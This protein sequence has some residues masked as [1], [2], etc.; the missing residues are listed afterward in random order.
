MSITTPAAE[1]QRNLLNIEMVR[2]RLREDAAIPLAL[3]S[4]SRQRWNQAGLPSA[5]RLPVRTH[6]R[7]QPRRVR[8][9]RPEFERA[10]IRNG[11][12]ERSAWWGSRPAA[13]PRRM[14]SVGDPGEPVMSAS[15]L[16]AKLRQAREN[17][18]AA[19]PIEGARR[20]AD[21]AQD[22]ASD[23]LDPEDL[24]P[25]VDALAGALLDLCDAIEHALAAASAR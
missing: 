14:A 2:K 1:L 23:A 25:A 19:R 15:D 22:I 5:V 18:R 7:P 11:Q 3:T 9:S 8:C 24:A 10:L 6:L 12:A 4:A 16:I 13:C 17:S 20:A 21:L